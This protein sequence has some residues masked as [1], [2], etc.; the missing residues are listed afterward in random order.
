MSK[1]KHIGAPCIIGEGTIYNKKDMLRALETVDGLR[2]E[3][4][5]DGKLIAA[6]EASLAKAFAS[7]NSATLLIKGC[8]FVNVFSFNYLNFCTLPNGETEIELIG[9][10]RTLRLIASD[11]DDIPNARSK[12]SPGIDVE[13][14]GDDETYALLED[15]EEDDE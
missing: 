11:E 12:R 4:Y 15:I 8:L 6:G 9:D 3:D 5:V 1:S 10:A 7:R 13:E 2:Y 14:Y